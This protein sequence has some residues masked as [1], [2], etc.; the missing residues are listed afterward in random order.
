MSKYEDLRNLLQSKLGAYTNA[1]NLLNN[2]I[3]TFN[4]PN[5]AVEY[6]NNPTFNNDYNILKFYT[7]RTQELQ[8]YFYNYLRPAQPDNYYDTLINH[9]NN[10]YPSSEEINRCSLEQIKSLYYLGTI[11]SAMNIDPSNNHKFEISEVERSISN[12][13]LFHLGAINRPYVALDNNE[14]SLFRNFM[15][16]FDIEQKM[17]NYRQNT[18]I[19]SNNVK[20]WQD[21]YNNA[22]TDIKNLYT[23]FNSGAINDIKNYYTN[24]TD[25]LN[26]L[27]SPRTRYF[28]ELFINNYTR[29]NKNNAGESVSYINDPLLHVKL[30][31]LEGAKI[32][33]N[34]FNEQSKNI[35]INNTENI[36]DIANYCHKL[37]VAEYISGSP[38]QAYTGKNYSQ[39]LYNR[40]K[41]FLNNPD[42]YNEINFSNVEKNVYDKYLSQ[43][44][45]N[46]GNSIANEINK[47]IPIT[48]K[49]GVF[50]SF[51]LYDSNANVLNS[52]MNFKNSFSTSI[53]GAKNKFNEIAINSVEN[54]F[55]NL[56]KPVTDYQSNV[57]SLQQLDNRTN[58][59]SLAEVSELLKNYSDWKTINKGLDIAV[60]QTN[61]ED[62]NN[63]VSNYVELANKYGEVAKKLSDLKDINDKNLQNE[64]EIVKANIRS[65]LT[66]L[67]DKDKKSSYFSRFSKEDVMPSVLEKRYK[68]FLDNTEAA[69]NTETISATAANPA[70][71]YQHFDTFYNNT[72]N[73]PSRTP[74]N[75]SQLNGI[76]R[77]KAVYRQN[78]NG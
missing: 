39:N 1:Q 35:F 60:S 50:L 40:L 67:L 22:S 15:N 41:F 25:S 59:I 72:S 21:L 5:V 77:R 74:S 43:K 70:I 7:N 29:I 23:N 46:L 76:G 9:I 57:D 66:Y 78:S 54:H 56:L 3:Q 53:N 55:K 20:E 68:S 16:N 30:R 19:L 49:N 64:G 27:T 18:E 24:L 12:R 45:L 13:L 69:I 10:I 58:D 65:H 26:K 71:D 42:N 61:L 44:V 4:N 36:K 51:G 33:Q 52:Y 34:Q 75:F 37:G 8:T 38:Y 31:K 32:F 2:F 14:E 62:I 73:R 28:D 63:K 17:A 48:S 47:S 11:R 6:G